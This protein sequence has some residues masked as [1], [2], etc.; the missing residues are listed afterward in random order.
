ML[1]SMPWWKRSS[2]NFSFGLWIESESSPNPIST[3]SRPSSFLKSATTGM[4]PPSRVKCGVWP[5]TPSS[6]FAAAFIAER[7]SLAKPRNKLQVFLLGPATNLASAILLKPEIAEVIHARYLGFWY[8]PATGQYDKKE[9][10]TGNDTLALNLLLDNPKLEFTVMTATSSE[11]LQMTREELNTSLPQ[12]HRLTQYLQTRWD[13]F[14]RW[15]TEQD[16]DKTQWTMWDVA[17]IEAWFEPQWA[18]LERR[19]APPQN[20][21]RQIGVYTDID[22][23]SMR[24]HYF[25][26]LRAWMER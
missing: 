5:N 1:A 24:T 6:A 13:G 11:Q 26:T 12:D 15:W 17:S 18:S 25:A 23:D 19:P 21:D 7:A 3:V 22:A 20:L 9:F 16:P 10:N 2:P 8:D 4:E 14:D